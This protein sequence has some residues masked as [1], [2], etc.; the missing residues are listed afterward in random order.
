MRDVYVKAV[1][2]E[3]SYCRHKVSNGQAR[4]DL[5]AQQTEHSPRHT[6]PSLIQ[7]IVILEYHLPIQ[8]ASQ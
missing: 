4:K 1:F 7:H 3:R 8:A 6:M 2:V 5:D